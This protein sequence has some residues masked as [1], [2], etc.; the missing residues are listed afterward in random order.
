M[1]QSKDPEDRD[2][3][4]LVARRTSEIGLRI[5]LGA[6]HSR[7][8]VMVLRETVTLA[9]IGITVGVPVT[10]MATR[11]VAGRLSG[12]G[13]GDAVTMAGA[14]VLMVGVADLAGFVPARRAAIDPMI[15][16]RR[17]E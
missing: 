14:S 17:D 8:L 13:S 3:I 12:I 1:A 15:A 4:E 10:L 16:L 7:V 11:T 6:A 2:V 9:L 5:A